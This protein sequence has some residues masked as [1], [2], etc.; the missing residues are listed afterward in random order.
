MQTVVEVEGLLFLDLSSASRYVYC[1]TPL[2]GPVYPCM[3]RS[4]L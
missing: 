2:T 1:Q 3:P 4:F